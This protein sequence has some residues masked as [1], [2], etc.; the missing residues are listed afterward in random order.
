MGLN[1]NVYLTLGGMVCECQTETL[2]VRF[3]LFGYS[4]Y[5]LAVPTKGVSLR[6]TVILSPD[7]F[8][9]F[10]ETSNSSN[11]RE[12]KTLQIMRLMIPDSR[13]PNPKS[14]KSQ[15]YI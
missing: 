8:E 9:R 14:L 1:N 15:P 13:S 5:E 3:Q 10:C 7:W 2:K 4:H 12:N 11:L 6:R